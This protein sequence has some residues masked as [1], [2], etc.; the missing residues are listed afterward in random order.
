M[1]MILL[2]WTTAV[3]LLVA[4]GTGGSKADSD[5][6]RNGEIKT[7]LSNKKRSVKHK[8]TSPFLISRGLPHMSNM[9]KKNW[10]NPELALTTDQK[11]RLLKIRQTVM[12]LVKHNKSKIVLLEKEIIQSSIYGVKSQMLKQKVER[13][14]SLKAEATLGHLRCNEQ[15][16]AILPPEQTA[17][18]FSHRK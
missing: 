15:T 5:C 6:Q 8:Y 9:L 14:A 18:L 10:D 17:Y 1:K 16:K 2:I 12:A 7:A 13:V 3:S 4:N 11:K